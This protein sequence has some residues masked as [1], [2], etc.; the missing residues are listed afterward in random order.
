MLSPAVTRR[1]VDE[2]GHADGSLGLAQAQARRRLAGLT[3]RELDVASAV[4]DG[5]SN[6][7]ISA[8]LSVAESTV[9]GYLASAMAKVH[10]TNRTPL[11][12]LAHDAGYR[13]PRDEEPAQ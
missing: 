8:R 4:A 5:L 2:F 7:E 1:V 13:L 12:L 3:P 10:A 6:A 9:K 11:A